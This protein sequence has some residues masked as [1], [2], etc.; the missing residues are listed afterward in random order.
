MRDEYRAITD[1]GFVLQID[2]PE[3]CIDRA[4]EFR[5]RPLSEFQARATLLVEA[6]NH[7]LDGIPE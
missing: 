1:A 5:D 3:M 6:L 2:A 4:R 7:A